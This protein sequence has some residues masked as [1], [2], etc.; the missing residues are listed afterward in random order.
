M[1]SSAGFQAAFSANSGSEVDDSAATHL[2]C[3]PG[4]SS[5]HQ[6]QMTLL[7]SSI[8]GAST[9]AFMRLQRDQQIQQRLLQRQQKQQ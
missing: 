3:G 1:T 7:E 8:L 9:S 4:Q 2:R 6:C 5:K